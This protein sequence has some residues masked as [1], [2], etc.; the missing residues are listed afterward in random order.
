MLSS[1]TRVGR[2]SG[3]DLTRALLFCCLL[4]TSGCAEDTARRSTEADARAEVDA[5]PDVADE[6]ANPRDAWVPTADTDTTDTET[7]DTDSTDTDT[8]DTDTT[9]TD[10]TD[11]DTT[12]TDSTDTDSTA[13]DTD[14]D[15]T[16]L[17]DT[18]DDAM[19]DAADVSGPSN[20]GP[21]A[22]TPD[23]SA[24]DTSNPHDTDAPDAAP[25]CSPCATGRIRF[26]R[27][28]PNPV[29][30][31]LD[32]PELAPLAHHPIGLVGT[33]HHTLTDADGSF[34]LPIPA[35]RSCHLTFAALLPRDP[36]MPFTE[37]SLAV[38]STDLTTLPHI[39]S[40]PFQAEHLWAWSS[41]CQPEVP[42]D[43]VIRL[44]EGAGALA[45]FDTARTVLNALSDHFGPTDL[46]LAIV[47][48]RGRAWSCGSCYLDARF[49]GVT[50]AASGHHFPRAIF[51]SGT[52]ANPHHFTPSIIAHELGHF[53]LEL[54]SSPPLIGGAHGFDRRVSPVLA[55]SEGAATLI[56]QW[57]LIGHTPLPHRFFAVQQNVQYWVD[58]E[59]IGRTPMS[60]DSNLDLLVP[61]P[62]P[63]DPLDQ[64][65]SE[66]VVAAILW[67]LLDAHPEVTGEVIALGPLL[68]SVLSDPRL[69][70]V[71]DGGPDRGALGPDLVDLL[72]ALRC[73]PTLH[74]FVGPPSTLPAPLT[75]LLLE[76]PYDDLPLCPSGPAATP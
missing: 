12:D 65:L 10:T 21:D 42:L 20:P 70:D 71:R 40:P 58:L 37:P 50:L 44:T 62:R 38:L 43:L 73:D 3:A 16:A 51:L 61:L 47:W 24:P 68:L 76:F 26:E 22:D 46:D 32:P 6:V 19:D 63:L 14:S 48:Q 69:A 13:Q 67:D 27:R 72:D 4:L 33:S 25:A 15:E 28:A 57:A 55:W 34:T 56:G 2:R 53:A 41:A 36:S 52:N 7:T 11:T 54:W 29:L 9:D 30:T 8:T 66:G 39:G 5:E 1:A 59:A 23:V 31:A 18:V 75:N 45:A 64:P 49:S 35:G 74:P 60:D 17:F